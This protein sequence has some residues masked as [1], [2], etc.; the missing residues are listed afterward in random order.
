MNIDALKAGILN[1]DRV[2]LA[3]AITLAES[4]RAADREEAF[5]LINALLPFTGN[6]LRI[7]ITGAPGIG[8]STFIDAL[9][10]FLTGKGMKVAVL[11]IDPS[12]SLSGGSI[13][14]DKTRMEHLSGHPQAFIRPSPS[15]GELGGIG[16]HTREAMLL[17]EAAGYQVVFI[18]TVGVGQ[19][20][21]SVR[22][23]TDLF[24]LLTMT[25]TGDE[26]QGIKRGIMEA[27]DLVVINKA[28]LAG[29]KALNSLV[30]T[31]TYALHLFAARSSGQKTEVIPVSAL[32][33]AGLSEAWTAIEH[34]FTGIRANGWFEENRNAQKIHWMRS[35]LDHLIRT[36][37]TESPAF[38]AA[39]EKYEQAVRN[40]EISPDEAAT[41]IFRE[42]IPVVKDQRL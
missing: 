1:G 21:I 34:Y 24:L 14:G 17:C 12:S 36:S 18:E 23:I 9:G 28:D 4:R 20:E 8:K 38:R 39:L 26:L 27:V 42:V 32:N 3:R 16:R 40:N 30:E 33:G 35:T 22:D 37:V 11:A 7:G 6:S 2:A 5:A 41:R 19:S 25:G 15:S 13:L 31:L 29:K 10:S